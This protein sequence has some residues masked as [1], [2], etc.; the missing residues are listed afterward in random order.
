MRAKFV[1]ENINFQRGL[2]P[3]ASMDIGKNWTP[4]ELEIIYNNLLVQ[5][6]QYKKMFANEAWLHIPLRFKTSVGWGNLYKIFDQ[7]D[8]E[9]FEE[10]KKFILK[11]YNLTR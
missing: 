6:N 4:M 2:D 10:M 9:E 1:F 5:L 3:I 7:L 8:D 11:Y